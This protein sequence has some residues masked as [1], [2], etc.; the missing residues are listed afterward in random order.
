MDPNQSVVSIKFPPA[1]LGP[2]MA[3]PILWAPG[4]LGLFLQENPHAHKIPPV[5]GSSGSFLEAGGGSASFI[6]M[7][8]G[9]FLTEVG[10]R[11]QQT[12]EHDRTTLGSGSCAGVSK[13]GL[14]RRGGKS[15]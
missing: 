8:A 9:I 13:A 12:C 15:Q 4:I 11:I 7:G 1:F 10:P 14:L 2:E 3:A 6:F 5:R